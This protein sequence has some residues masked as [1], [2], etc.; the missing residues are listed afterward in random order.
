[1]RGK[2]AIISLGGSLVVP[3]EGID[4]PFLK[5]FSDAR[6]IERISWDDY[7]KLIGGKWMPGLR[8]PFDPVASK[9]AK[10]IGLKVII[11]HGH[12]FKNLD[13]ILQGKEF[14]GTVIE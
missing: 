9:L 7:L 4:I 2:P 14:V 8:V 11:C 13:N 10:K 12:N 3:E 6:P 1:M 5:K